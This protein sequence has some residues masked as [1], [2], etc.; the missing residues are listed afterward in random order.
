VPPWCRALPC[1]GHKA[2]KDQV[3]VAHVLAYQDLQPWDGLFQ[4]AHRSY[5][6][7]ARQLLHDMRS[8]GTE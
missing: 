3:L 7:R 5:L 4:S 8:G 2:G 6:V 1:S